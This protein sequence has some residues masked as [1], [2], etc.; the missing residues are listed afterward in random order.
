MH[1]EQLGLVP[2]I[3]VRAKPEEALHQGFHPATSAAQLP[4]AWRE[5]GSGRV[6]EDQKSFDVVVRGVDDLADSVESLRR[7]PIATPSGVLVPLAELA[8]VEVVSTPGSIKREDASRRL[9]VTSEVEGRDLGSVAG[10]IET[11]LGTLKLPAG[12]GP[13]LLGE[14]RERETRSTGS[15]CWAAW[16][17]VGIVL[18]LYADFRALR[19]T[20]LIFISLP[21]RAGRRRCRRA[22]SA[23]EC[24]RSA[25]WSGSSPCSGSPRATASCWSVITGTSNGTKAWRSDRA[26]S[27][28]GSIERV[29]PILMTALAT[30]LALL[31]LV[32]A[33]DRPGHEI[34]HPLAV[35]ISVVCSAR[36][37]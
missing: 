29:A 6:Y 14:H 37:S 21:V 11:R 7:L 17:C 28:R 26:W 25:H 35:V 33:G 19:P 30:M 31:P 24:F 16:R 12:Y 5:S 8:D 1:V 13:R 34:E 9:D 22:F 4:L 32:I 2:T 3:E 18:V 23:V 15:C 36:R 27:L 10:E 20:L